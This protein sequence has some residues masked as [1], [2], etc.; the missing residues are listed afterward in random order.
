MSTPTIRIVASAIAA[1]IIGSVTYYLI[2]H[3]FSAIMISG[4]V[5]AAAGLALYKN[6]GH[7]PTI[8]K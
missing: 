3:Q 7:I 6:W 2:T 4:L 8:T 1:L 5:G